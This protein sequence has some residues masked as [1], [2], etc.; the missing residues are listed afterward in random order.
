MNLT[1]Q[2]ERAEINAAIGIV[3]I[4][5]QTILPATPHFTADNLRV[6]PTPTIAPVIVWVVDTGVPVSVT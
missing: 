4:H 3:R 2:N 1:I 5:A 6:D